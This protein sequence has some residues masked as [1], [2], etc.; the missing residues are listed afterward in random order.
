MSLLIAIGTLAAYT[1]G[2]IDSIL[3]IYAEPMHG[4]STDVSTTS[5]Y[6]VCCQI[7]LRFAYSVD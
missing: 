3:A 2:V 6:N 7:D 5:W 4:S 1:Y